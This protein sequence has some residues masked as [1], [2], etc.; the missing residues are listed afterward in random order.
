MK[1]KFLK[2]ITNIMGFSIPI[3]SE[4]C[5]FIDWAIYAVASFALQTFFNLAEVSANMFVATSESNALDT[6]NNILSR[7]MVLAGVFALFRLGIMLINYII[8]PENTKKIGQTGTDFVKGAI[9]AVV[10]LAS[11]KTIFTQLG[12]FQW[13]VINNDKLIPKLVY[14]TDSSENP[15][16]YSDKQEAD[17]FTN[18]VWSLFFQPIEGKATDSA[19]EAWENVRNGDATIASMVGRNYNEFDYYPF[20]SGIVG[21][22]LIYYFAIFSIELGSRIIKLVVLQVLSPIPIIMSVD[23]SQKNKLV[24]FWKAYFAV[25]LQIF[26]RVLTIYL[27]FVVLD[28]LLAAVAAYGSGLLSTS[29]SSARLMV[30]N[31][32]IDVIMVFAVFQAAKELPKV[33]EDA[34]GLKLGIQTT[35]KGSFGSLV[36]GI[37]GGGAGLV[38][39]GIAG[40]VGASGS[41][42]ATTLGAGLIGA[43]SGV[44]SGVS[45]GSRGKTIADK[46]SGVSGS[47]RNAHRTGDIISDVGG[48]K[49]YARAKFDA[50]TG[51]L[52][53]LDRAT[54]KAED[55]KSLYKGFE[56][57]VY[58]DYADSKITITD[59][60]GRTIQQKVGK[61]EDDSKVYNAQLA[62]DQYRQSVLNGAPVNED[63]RQQL[64]QAVKDAQNEWKD[65]AF[66]WFAKENLVETQQQLD[67]SSGQPLEMIRESAPKVKYDPTNYSSLSDSQ[68][69]HYD[70]TRASRGEAFLPDLEHDARRRVGMPQGY[71]SSQFRQTFKNRYNKIED[72]AKDLKAEKQSDKARNAQKAMPPR[73]PMMDRYFGGPGGG[74]PKPPKK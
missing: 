23:P 20:I 42:W 38:G 61:M 13:L 7:V 2:N 49:N 52:S 72:R 64:S 29:T 68:R 16:T 65:R 59:N 53:R 36:G 1:Y 9:I 67:P 27:A 39:G 22:M 60:T 10:L 19:Y 4:L 34:L 32:V 37:I 11:S 40:A 63:Q 62:Y 45:A 41:G 25:Y 71:E 43:G 73:G 58:A 8:S 24:N 48:M 69:A 55:Q 15:V 44:V 51:Y 12:K 5:V 70:I 46:V 6:V 57:A 3:I 56:D 47:I 21:M 66:E 26:I 14:G 35:G 31:F 17:R 50:N 18:R 33:V 30:S 28:I 54:Q 74:G